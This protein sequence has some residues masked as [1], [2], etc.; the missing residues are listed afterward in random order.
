MIEEVK[1][2]LME[3]EIDIGE[4]RKGGMILFSFS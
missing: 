1:N 4:G 2:E 3:R